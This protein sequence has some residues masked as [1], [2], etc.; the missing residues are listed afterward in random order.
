IGLQR[1]EKLAGRGIVDVDVAVA[2]V[3]DEQI[4]AE[5]S[6]V[7]SRLHHAPGSIELALADQPLLELTVCGV[8]IDEAESGAL[9]V[10]FGVGILL[11]VANIELAADVG[12]AEGRVAGGQGAVRKCAGGLRDEGE[13][14]IEHVD[15][16]IVEVGGEEEVYAAFH[17]WGDAFVDSTI[18]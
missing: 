12:D 1:A 4:V 18:G 6:E 13:V 9:D 17:T 16:A 10:I 14:L 8:D 2:E 7:G 5:V 3:A 15:L 11:G